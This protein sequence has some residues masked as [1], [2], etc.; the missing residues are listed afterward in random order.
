MTATDGQQTLYEYDSLGRVTQV[1]YPDGHATLSEY[2]ANGNQTTLVVH[3][4]ADHVSTVNGINRVT[5][6]TTPL[7]E[8]THYEYDR[9]R[10]LTA[11]ELPSGQR[12]ENFYSQ[13]RLTQTNTPESAILYSYHH[14]DQISQ[15]TYAGDSTNL[16]TT[17]TACSPAFTAS[18]S[19]AMPTMACPSA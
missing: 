12:L 13:N 11:I 8:A 17:G 5:S 19:A 6:D 18:P 4:P 1:T 15:L 10:R 3:T 9:D 7:G 2:D 16:S 14:G